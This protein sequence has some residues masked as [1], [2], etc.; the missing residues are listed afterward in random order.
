MKVENTNDESVNETTPKLMIFNETQGSNKVDDHGSQLEFQEIIY[1]LNQ[2]LNLH[3]L[4]P[5][6]NKSSEVN[7]IKPQA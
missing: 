2:E 5:L 7:I 4:C 1:D 3:Y 6:E